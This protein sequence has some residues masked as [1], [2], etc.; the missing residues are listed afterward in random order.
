MKSRSIRD[1]RVLWTS[2]AVSAALHLLVVLLYSL[3]G[4]P[5]VG[6]IVLPG[7][8]EPEGRAQGTPLVAIN[9]VPD[10]ELEDPDAPETIEE[11]DQPDAPSFEGDPLREGEPGP[12]LVEPGRNGRTA[13]ELLRPQE[14][15]SLIWRQVDPALTE[16]TDHELAELRMQWSMTE[17]NEAMAAEQAAAEEA[18]DWTHTDSDGNKWGV[19]PGKLHLGSLT[20]PL[21]ISFDGARGR[22]DEVDRRLQEYYAAERQAGRARVWETWEARAKEI[23]KRKDRE[24]EAARGEKPDTVRRR[25]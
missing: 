15:D 18:L 24:R 19:S 22:S 14:G 17:W 25:R 11:P 6:P 5:D 12:G 9:I 10:S 8:A 3:M 20:L 7:V 4:R 2:L 23:R 13:A 21:P 16:L 1:R